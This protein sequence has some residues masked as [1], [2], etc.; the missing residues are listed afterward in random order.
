MK[1]ILLFP[2]IL[3]ACGGLDE[4]TRHDISSQN[5]ESSESVQ[6]IREL[7]LPEPHI[8]GGNTVRF[9]FS[10]L[11]NSE[12]SDK[13]KN[14]KD[15]WLQINDTIEFPGLEEQIKKQTFLKEIPLNI[16]S[17]CS[18]FPE[19]VIIKKFVRDLS[20]SIP[21]IELLPEEVLY[22]AVKYG[23]HISP[24]CGFSFT[25]EHE[26]GAGH[27]FKLPTL[28]I[29]DYAQSNSII[30]FDPPET[31]KTKKDSY[32]IL[33]QNKSQYLMN[34][35]KKEK[36]VNKLILN[37][38][39]FSRTELLYKSQFVPISIFTLTRLDTDTPPFSFFS[40][41]SRGQEEVCRIFGYRDQVLVAVSSVF[42]LSY[43]PSKRK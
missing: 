42:H 5:S 4:G 39:T 3:S 24:H 21:L 40:I 33:V 6:E 8:K 14:N 31:E 37:C 15:K 20:S 38:E 10:D 12:G 28:P 25:V 2:L 13:N 23:P 9:K 27:K 34:V 26:D 35:D 36:S 7:T 29:R 1:I 17:R 43:P 16:S 30:F 11:E 18:V 41:S 19:R 32:D 22:S